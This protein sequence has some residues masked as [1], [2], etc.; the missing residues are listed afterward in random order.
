[1]GDEPSAAR[2]GAAFGLTLAASFGC[3]LGGSIVFAEG[4]VRRVDKRFLAASRHAH[5]LSH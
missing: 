2:M 4:F 5:G 1:M 3:C